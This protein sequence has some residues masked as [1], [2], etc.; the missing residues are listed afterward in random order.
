MLFNFNVNVCLSF[1][2]KIDDNFLEFYH[3][4]CKDMYDSAMRNSNISDEY[5][6]TAWK[7]IAKPYKEIESLSKEEIEK[8][9]AD[10]DN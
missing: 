8:I 4:Y 5:M 3:S 7:E 2:V 6:S 9:L 1:D 10:K